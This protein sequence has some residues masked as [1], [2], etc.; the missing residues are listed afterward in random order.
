MKLPTSLFHLPRL[1]ATLAVAAALSACAS[2]P[3]KPAPVLSTAPA[4]VATAAN[5]PE[6]ASARQA[7]ALL[8]E[9]H[10]L[11]AAKDYIKAAAAVQGK[12]QLQYLLKAAQA[13]LQGNRAPV[14]VLLADEVL[15]LEHDDNGLRGQA[16]WV[17]AQGLM[18]QGQTPRAKGNLEELLTIAST[19]QNVRAEAMGT[20]ATLY[21]QEG[22]ELTALNFLIERDSLLSSAA[23]HKN[24]KRIHALL[25]SVSSARIQNWQGRSGNPL[26]Q[27]WLAIALISRHNPDPDQRKAAINAWMAAHPG[28][29]PINFTSHD[30]L[31]VADTTSSQ[32]GSICALLP[33]T[34]SYA[35]LSQ[36]LSAGMETAEQLASG[37]AVKLLQSTGNP[38]Y[39]AVLFERGVKEGCQIFVGPLLPQDI[40][41]VASVRKP[42][43][44]PVIALGSDAGVQQP[45]LYTFSLSRDVAAR[46]IANQGYAAGYRRVYV[47]YPQDS[48]GAAIQADF[49][50]TW[51]KLGGSVSGVATYL[52]GHSL[53]GQ[54]QQLLSGTI[55]RHD[56]VFLVADSKN[57][58]AA[59]T[60]IRSINSNIPI[61]S[62]ALLHGAT[63]PSDAQ[64]LSG[65]ESVDMPWIIQP[66]TTK[67]QAAALLHTSLPNASDAQWRMAAFGMD[68]YQ[69]AEKILARQFSQ[70]LKGATGTLHF[71]KGGRIV[72]DMEWMEVENGAIVPLPAIP[73]PGS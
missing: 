21:T 18:D 16:L 28:H 65:I 35:G 56:F 32:E 11:E 23:I 17:R 38:S 14:A 49:I 68:A 67:P 50:D 44:P 37:P 19:P 41:A 15:R 20:L 34:G 6:A 66:A 1:T 73:K 47:L 24:H 25:D 64:N 69:L 46:Q 43:D 55:S 62:P 36:A 53:N 48:S 13:S 42:S 70:P 26:V 4:P 30:E 54:A 71:G 5:S 33:S 27:E 7:D 52:P 10:D 72:R 63:L 45:G 9:G 12:T 57:A 40:N 39:T 59:V 29:P 51:K 3:H 61:F 60:A 22:H 58:N 8:A 31:N 2:M